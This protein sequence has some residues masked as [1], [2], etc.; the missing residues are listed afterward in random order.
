[1][2]SAGQWHPEA[3][4]PAIGWNYGAVTLAERDQGL[5]IKTPD[6]HSDLSPSPHPPSFQDYVFEKPLQKGGFISITLTWDRLVELVDKN[7][8]GEFDMEESFR[9]RGLNTLYLYLMRAEDTDTRKSIWSSI[10]DV[11]SLQHLFHQIPETGQYKIRVV[12][13]KRVNEAVQPYAIAWWSVPAR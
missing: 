1:Q 3:P 9:D 7:K 12:F 4:V 13:Q 2:F 6:Q 10:S 11:D 8:N 5:T